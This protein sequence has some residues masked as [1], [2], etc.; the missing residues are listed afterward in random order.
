MNHKIGL[1]LKVCSIAK[2]HKSII[3]LKCTRNLNEMN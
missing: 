2:K 1:T 3:D